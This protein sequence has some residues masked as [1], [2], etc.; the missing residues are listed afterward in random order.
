MESY[1][2]VVEEALFSLYPL[3]NEKGMDWMF[4]NCSTTAQRGL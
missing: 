1:N 2:E 3:I 4:S